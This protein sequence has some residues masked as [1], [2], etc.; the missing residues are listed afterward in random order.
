MRNVKR[1][2]GKGNLEKG[3]GK[4]VLAGVAECGENSGDAGAPIGGVAA[5]C[6]VR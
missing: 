4:W 3:A 2:R 1:G 6:V 5:T